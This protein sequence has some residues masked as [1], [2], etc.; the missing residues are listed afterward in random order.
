MRIVIIDDQRLFAEVLAVALA[1]EGHEISGVAANAVEAEELVAELAPDILL[2]DVGSPERTGLALG[3]DLMARRPETKIIVLTALT[4]PAI[5]RQALRIGFHGVLTKDASIASVLSAIAAVSEG[6]V[7]MPRTPA[8]ESFGVLHDEWEV[9][10]VARQL[11]A[12]ELEVLRLLAEAFTNQRIATQLSISPNTVRTHVQAILTKL[13]VHSR[14]EAAA[15]ALRHGLV[16]V[17]PL[18][19]AEIWPRSLPDYTRAAPKDA[20]G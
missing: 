6:Q 19:S 14:L 11:T 5:A 16:E 3:K 20:S 9:D 4:N 8:R 18:G 2:L 7:A 10:I 15:F 17:P 12:R 1:D 13:Q